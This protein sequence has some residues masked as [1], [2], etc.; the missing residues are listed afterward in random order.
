MVELVL[1][2]PR[3]IGK[4]A[5]IHLF[6]D[7]SLTFIMEIDVK[8][9]CAHPSYVSMAESA[10]MSIKQVATVSMVIL[11][12]NAKILT[13]LVDKDALDSI[14]YYYNTSFT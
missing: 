8:M 13:L 10:K 6:A 4:K 11:V 2:Y 5:W 14:K 3:P 12:N 9:K 7:A 1:I